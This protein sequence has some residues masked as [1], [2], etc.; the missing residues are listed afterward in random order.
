MTLKEFAMSQCLRDLLQQSSARHSH[1]CPRQVLG[2]RMG[3]AGL[4][5]LGLAAPIRK[6][7]ALIIVE[8]DGCFADGIEVST[9]ATIGNRSLRVNDFGKI[10]A[11]FVNIHSGYAIRI[12]PTLDVRQRA[13]SYA[14]SEKNH[15][16]AQLLGYQ[17]MSDSEL[18][19]FQAVILQPSMNAIISRPGVRVNCDQCG[20][21]VINDRQV[22]INN[23]TLCRSCAHEGY[24]LPE[25]Y[26]TMYSM[27]GYQSQ[28]KV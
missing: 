16:T 5:E 22:H 14:S 20:E 3:L 10:A 21:E 19:R 26:A 24:Y 17:A 25:A 13:Q 7:T 28:I 11:T 27:L 8:T 9:T 23:S 1:L 4:A 2:V 6:H 15:Y 18:F 12:S